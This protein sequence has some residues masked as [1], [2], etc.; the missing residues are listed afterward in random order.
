M[1]NKSDASPLPPSFGYMP[2]IIQLNGSKKLTQNFINPSDGTI[3]ERSVPMMQQKICVGVFGEWILL[4]DPK[5]KELTL[6]SV[7]FDQKFSLPRLLEPLESLGGFILTS[8]PTSTK[9][10][11]FIVSKGET[12]ILHCRPK[13]ENWTKVKVKLDTRDNYCFRG[14]ISIC[15]G[16][17]YALLSEIEEIEYYRY[18]RYDTVVI[19]VEDFLTG[20]F[21]LS[22][23]EYIRRINFIGWCLVD[24]GATSGGF[25]DAHSISSNETNTTTTYKRI[26]N[27]SDVTRSWTDM[28]LDLVNLLCSRL[29]VV[30]LMR[31][32]SV[33]KAWTSLPTHSMDDKKAWPLLL[34]YSK[35][36]STCR[37]YDPIYG[38]QYSCEIKELESCEKIWSSNN[39]WILL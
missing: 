31:L 28:P 18:G 20:S 27:T 30:E 9:C 35:N 23:S 16:K 5:S 37:L 34:Q 38:Y 21:C 25:Q 1:S 3:E 32:S 11:A 26:E 15:K 17:L 12:F 24:Q 33:C 29:N 4:M 19:D 10:K 7:T 13:D 14:D 6:F 22:L 8:D 2:W 39:G 36:S